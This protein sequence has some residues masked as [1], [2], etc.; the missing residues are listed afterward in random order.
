MHLDL[1]VQLHLGNKTP[2]LRDIA[3]LVAVELL[4][5]V[6]ALDLRCGRGRIRHHG[7]HHHARIVVRIDL[8]GLQ[9]GRLDAEITAND[10]P[11]FEQALQR[12]PHSVR[13]DGKTDALGA[14]A[15]RNNCGV[16]ADDFAAQIDEWPAAI[17]G[18]DR[19]ICLQ[20]ITE[21]VDAIGPSLRADNTV[22]HGFFEAEWIAH[23]EHEIACL[24]RVG[25]A[26]LERL[27][28]GLVHF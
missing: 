20:Q 8:P 17:P 10:T 15:A 18:I 19:G 3:H 13:R 12:H 16:N 7:R 14:P 25:I 6:A 21:A 26:E 27:R 23:R 11:L 4:D 1:L 5:H 22:R 2:Q 24:H 9:C 28:S